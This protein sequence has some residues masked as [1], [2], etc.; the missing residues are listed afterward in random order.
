MLLEQIVALLALGVLIFAAGF[1]S[2]YRAALIDQIKLK[3][4][5]RRRP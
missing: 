4:S 1:G 3:Y 5:P 2:G